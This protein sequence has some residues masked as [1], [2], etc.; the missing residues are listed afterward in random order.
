[1]MQ[2]NVKPVRKI[3]PMASLIFAAVLLVAGCASQP[4]VPTDKYYRLQAV[5]AAA[6]A[7]TPRF[8]GNFQVERFT[9]DGLTAGRPIVYV[10]SNDGNQLLEYHYHFWTQPPTVMLRDE[11]V[12]YLRASKIAESVVTPDMRLDPQYVMTGRIRKLEQVLGSPNRTRLELEIALRQTDNNKLM[13]LK[14]YLHESNQTSPG[15]SSAVDALNEALNIIYSDLLAD[16][17][18]L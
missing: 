15:V 4:P 12:T 2:A 18:S 16:L 17:R 13:F 9:A 3:M 8:Q 5:L 1:M 10:E 14:S 6:P 7:S 11:L